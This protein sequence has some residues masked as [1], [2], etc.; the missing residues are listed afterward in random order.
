[1]NDLNAHLYDNDLSSPSYINGYPGKTSNIRILWELHGGLQHFELDINMTQNE[2]YQFY[3]YYLGHRMIITDNYLD[4][5]VADGFIAGISVKPHGVHVIAEGFWFR[6]FDEYYNFDDL[7]QDTNQGIISYTMQGVSSTFTDDGQAWSDWVGSGNASYEI[8]VTNGDGS[9]STGFL[10]PTVSTTEIYVYSTY[11]LDTTG[12]LSRSMSSSPSSYEVKKCY[13]YKTTTDIVMDAASSAVPSIDYNSSGFDETSTVIGFWEPPID[14]GGMYPGDLINKLA[15]MS[16][17]TN[18]QWNYY[19]KQQ[20]LNVTTLRKPK[21]IFEPQKD[22]GTFNWEIKR[23][24]ISKGSGTIERNIQEMRNA[25]R[26]IYRDM[27]NDNTVTLEP[28]ADSA[29]NAQWNSD[30]DSISDYWR[31]E[32]Y[33]SGGDSTPAIAAQYSDLYLNKYKDSMAKKSIAISSAFIYD[34]D[35]CDWPLW[36]PI[37]YS[38]SWFKIVDLFPLQDVLSSSWDRALAFQ[39]ITMEYSSDNGGELR[40]HLDTEDDSLTALLA[41]VQAY[42]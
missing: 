28:S 6:H 5:P 35:G 21:P 9:T 7:A 27:S 14:E 36:A 31:R 38:K 8:E 39:A 42:R 33:L 1:M 19:V 41:R 34:E 23:W 20:T 15:S 30:S 26:I 40:L 17:S 16:D 12:W 4:M 10:G 24:M 25:V 37:K 29:G 13:D 2:A 22:D 32:I 11:S 18:R 3:R